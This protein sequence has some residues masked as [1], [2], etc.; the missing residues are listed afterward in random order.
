MS[1]EPIVNLQS[2]Q[3]FLTTRLPIIVLQRVEEKI[4]VVREIMDGM[5]LLEGELGSSSKTCVTST[6]AGNEM[7][8]EAERVSIMTEEVQK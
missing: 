4:L 3:E 5:N 1:D 2:S 7:R 6:L 8:I